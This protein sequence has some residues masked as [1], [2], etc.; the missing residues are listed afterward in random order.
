MTIKLPRAKE[1]IIDTLRRV[2]E[3]EEVL[4]GAALDI[5][6]DALVASVV[7]EYADTAFRSDF[8]GESR[9]LRGRDYFK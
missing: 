2:M 4:P 6:A 7:Q 8:S 3:S 9:A 1:Q 5:L